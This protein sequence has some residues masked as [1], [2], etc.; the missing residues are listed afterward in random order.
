M[1]K[2]SRTVTSRNPYEDNRKKSIKSDEPQQMEFKKKVKALI[3]G[4]FAK[5]HDL[6]RHQLDKNLRY[7]HKKAISDTY[8][9]SL[10]CEQEEKQGS[11]LINKLCQG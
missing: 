3:K 10:L 11:R 4:K 8:Q 6:G 1:L 2:P 9:V 5:L 7:S